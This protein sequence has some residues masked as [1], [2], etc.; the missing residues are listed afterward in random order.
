MSQNHVFHPQYN[1]NRFLVPF[2]LGAAIA[3]PLYS[4][5]GNC[6]NQNCYLGYPYYVPPY[7]GYYP[8]GNIP[9]NNFQYYNYYPNY[10]TYPPYRENEGYRFLNL[11]PFF[12]NININSLS[13]KW[14]HGILPYNPVYCLN[15][16]YCYYH[17]NP[18]Y[19]N[20]FI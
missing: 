17:G 7:G 16:P 1:S 14:L 13:K 8:Y 6:A 5:K 3:Y 15:S 18:Y 4:L 12:S 11:S 2:L 9:L 19:Q 20:S 10:N